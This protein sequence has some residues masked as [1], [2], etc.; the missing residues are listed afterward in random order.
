M[1]LLQSTCHGEPHN[2]SLIMVMTVIIIIIVM[3][4]VIVVIIVP[5][6][7]KIFVNDGSG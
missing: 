7:R 1:Y 4:V 2:Q 3:I 5:T 6:T